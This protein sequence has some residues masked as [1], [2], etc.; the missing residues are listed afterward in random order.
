MCAPYDKTYSNYIMIHDQI[1]MDVVAV[2][3]SLFKIDHYTYS[4]GDLPS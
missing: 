3:A 2:V 1:C 4:C